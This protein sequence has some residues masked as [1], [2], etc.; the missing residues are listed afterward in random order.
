M[1]GIPQRLLLLLLIMAIAAPACGSSAQP[2][3]EQAIESAKQTIQAEAR[4]TEAF[5]TAVAQ[6]V[7]KT[8]VVQPTPPPAT[9][10]PQ[11]SQPT[12]APAK[13]TVQPHDTIMDILLSIRTGK[14]SH[15]RHGFSSDGGGTD[16]TVHFVL[17]GVNEKGVPYALQFKLDDP[18][19][20][21]RE[22]GQT[23]T[24]TIAG[25]DLRL[26]QV[27]HASVRN[28]GFRKSETSAT[29]KVDG[30]WLL[31]YFGVQFKLADGRAPTFSLAPNQWF[32]SGDKAQFTWPIQ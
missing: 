27:S 26:N 24:Y 5:Q 1:T 18:S 25:G 7:A 17:E 16:D 4:E 8:A 23:D 29:T 15:T 19:K 31:E 10:T 3:Q 6:A 22:Q 12:P 20:N 13:P 21:D 9:N 14:G 11:P 2:S 28:V 32:S 30:D